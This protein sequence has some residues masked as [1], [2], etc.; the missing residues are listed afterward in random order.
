ML[1][2][3]IAA[4][5]PTV[6]VA[7]ATPHTRG[8]Q[9]DAIGSN[10]PRNTRRRTA[11]AAALGPVERNADTGAGAPSYTSGALDWKGT[12]EILNAKPTKIS[13]AATPASATG[14]EPIS[15]SRRIKTRFV[16]PVAP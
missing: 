6:M 8:I 16:E 9:V 10:A 2:C 11:N 5:F 14:W 1:D 15:S 4:K 3:K 7:S 13:A 12:A